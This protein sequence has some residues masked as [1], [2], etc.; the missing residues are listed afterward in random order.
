MACPIPFVATTY[1]WESN[2]AADFSDTSADIGT[3]S[4]T[5]T[6]TDADADQYIRVTVTFTDGRGTE[7][8]RTS[9][10]TEQITRLANRDAE[11]APAISG[12]LIT[13]Q[14]LTAGPGSLTD[15]DGLP[16]PFVATY[17]WESNPAADFSDTSAD[18][19]TNSD[20]YTLTDA[21]ADQYIRV[22]VTFTDGR[23]NEETR[24]SAITEQITRQ[25]N[26]DAEGAPAISG[27]LITLQELTAGPGSLTDTDG[28]PDP[29]V[30]TYLWE[31]NPAADFSDTS[32]DIG[33]N[34]NTY[35]L[36]DADADQ[37]IRVTVTFTDGRGTEE[38][39]TSAITEQITRQTNRDAEGAPAISG[40]LITLQDL[41]AGPG[42]LT[43]TDGLPNPFV[44]TYLWES[45]PAADFSD[46][47]AD[48]GTNS[49][50]YTLTDA[51]ADQYIRVTVTFTDGRG[52]EETRTSAI[53]E[54]IT[55]LANRDAEGAPAI[56]GS[57]ITLQEL[58]A[59][60]GSL[61][62]TDGLP[63]PF[64]A[65]TYLWQSNPAADF[66]DTSADIGTNSNTYT[67]TDADADQYIRVTVT[68]TDGRG[69][70]ETRTSAIT[71]Q[72]TRLAN[73]DAEGA[74]AIS[75]SLITLQDLT[76]GPGSLTDTDGLPN[77][78]VATYLWESNPAA[79]FSDTSAD[80]GT[81]SNTY[82][83]T[84]ADA[85]QYIRVTVTFTDGRGNEETRTSAI[86]EQITRLA[87][88]DAEGAP[89]IS[90]S[91]ITL[92]ELTAGPGS[93]TDTDGLPNPFVATTYLWQSNPAADFSD[94]SADIGTNSNTYTLTDADA[95]QYIRVT[96]TFTDGRGTEE[97]RTS[98][99]TEQITRQT[100][101]DA[102]GAPAISG[103]LITLQELTAGPGS[104]TDTD[105]LP[106]PFVATYLWESNPAA[107]FSDTSAD[108]GT[109]SNTY[110]LTDADADQYIRVTVT[111][112]DGRG[113]EETRTSAITEQITRL[114]NRDAEGAPAI[115]GSLITLQ[116]LTAGP[117]SL[118]DT[119][120]L[121]NPFVATYL[122][123]S[124]PAADFSDTSAD[125]GTNSNTYT[126]TDA[127]ADQYIRV[128]VTF[129]DGRGT[130]ETRT[131]AI[132]EQIT[133]LA[134]R[135]AE[136]APAI[137]G[138]LITLQELTAGPG[139]LTDT[140]GLPDPFV[141]T[142]LWE[143]NPAADF[144]DTSA[145]IGTNSNTYTLTDADA[146]QYIR[147]TVT[148]TDGRG[149][150][151]PAHPPSPS[152]SPDR[153]IAMPRAHRPSA[154]AS[155]PYKS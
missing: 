62:D 69:T 98:A 104:L 110:T 15:T 88:R 140:D 116:E 21:D 3:N 54:Q 13:L 33:T 73:R 39:R 129:T 118:T 24:T 48:I 28:L 61:T 41:T 142:Y 64:V 138:S 80:I 124:N 47:S 114:A 56:S 40:S 150:K 103:S 29:F 75:G 152:R 25:T 131:S 68:F 12:S 36:T 46:T 20:T 34:S 50:T 60:P 11:G 122:W 112:T 4:N 55:R 153:P 5:Y 9:A 132:T 93:L 10:I 31:S 146:D 65:T 27:S 120:G 78:F 115:S 77:P 2:P 117:G 119:D 74:P 90:G 111:F 123:E 92:Q 19:G 66:S 108:I 58:T 144:S 45:N 136:G 6:L 109:N 145:D 59:G 42:S 101:R 43:D 102:E 107:D 96:V 72:I 57:L 106:D 89:A 63:N 81:N 135:D 53:T 86:T 147:V 1:L 141:A 30:A 22:T 83:L 113:N 44:A 26:R 67:L 148:F 126:L 16:N 79:D 149:K 133:R 130:E 17:L 49:N 97:T 155:S 134:N 94:T 105:G 127:D 18:I 70:E 125:I 151:K 23:G 32:A 14:E 154:V 128:T 100:N 38:T 35:T 52:N 76:A 8:T 82:T 139:S 95:D 137:S 87:N 51:D 84:D 85:D 71:E 143:S 91:L 7:E 37:Y 121:P 99:I